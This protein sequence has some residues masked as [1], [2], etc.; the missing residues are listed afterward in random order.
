MV[1]HSSRVNYVREESLRAITGE[2]FLAPETHWGVCRE[3]REWVLAI[4]RQIVFA[5]KNIMWTCLFFSLTANRSRW[6]CKVQAWSA[7]SLWRLQD[8]M[9]S[10]SPWCMNEKLGLLATWHS[11][12]ILNPVKILAIFVQ[13]WEGGRKQSWC[14]IRALL[15]L[16]C[17]VLPFSFQRE[18]VMPSNRQII[19]F[20]NRAV[21]YAI[22]TTAWIAFSLNKLSIF[23]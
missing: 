7:F 20:W 19:Y 8:T 5:V 16:F 3:H 23:L 21:A 10:F 2:R 6:L 4:F 11:L 17:C 14:Y 1:S 15:G 22:Y 13:N 18:S 12:C 9:L